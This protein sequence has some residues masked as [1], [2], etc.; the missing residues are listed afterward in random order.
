MQTVIC[1]KWGTLYGAEYVNRLYSM[2]MRHTAKPTRFICF[3]EDPSGIS[4]PV[5]IH[6]LPEINIPAH[7]AWT[8]WRKLSLWQYPLVDLEGDVLFLDLDIVVTGNID[9]FFQYKP[10][11]FAVIEN[12]TQPN[13][14]IGNTSVFRFPVGKYTHIFDKFNRDPQV[15]L[16]GYRIEQQYISAEIRDQVFW[17]EE[18]CLSFK[19]SL[20]PQWPLNFFRAPD[21][22]QNARVIAF[23]GMPNP[24]D[25]VMGNWPEKNQLKKIYKHVKPTA[26]VGEHWR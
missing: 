11:R 6:P 22:P 1:V 26:W 9:D 24:K 18:W 2:V 8:P 23:T 12:W 19:H 7:V 13:S 21:L 16:D 14:Q 15:V 5:E 25:A 4:L 3:T 17:P 20:M 10:G